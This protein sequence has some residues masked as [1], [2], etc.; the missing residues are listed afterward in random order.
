VALCFGIAGDHGPGLALALGA[1][2]AGAGAVASWMRLAA[3]A[4]RS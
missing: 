2:F 3:A 1:A 4:P